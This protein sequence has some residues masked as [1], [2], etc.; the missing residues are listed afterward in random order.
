MTQQLALFGGGVE[1]A[2]AVSRRRSVVRCVGMAGLWVVCVERDGR[3]I[4]RKS[5]RERTNAE[6]YRDYLRWRMLGGA[7]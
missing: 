1:T 5:F 7:A 6:T 3:L 2:K 4:A